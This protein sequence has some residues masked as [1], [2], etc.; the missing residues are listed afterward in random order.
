MEMQI[1]TKVSNNVLSII[2]CDICTNILGSVGH[3]PPC[4]EKITTAASPNA[5]IKT[6][7][8]RS[9]VKKNQRKFMGRRRQRL[10]KLIQDILAADPYR[11]ITYAC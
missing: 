2:S 9:M 1:L 5:L 11:G 10:C 3:P 8:S 4:H 6:T 7:E